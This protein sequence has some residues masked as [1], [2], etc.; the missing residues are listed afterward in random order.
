[1]SAISAWAGTLVIDGY[2]SPNN[3]LA[4]TRLG[5]DGIPVRC[6]GGVG[7][8]GFFAG[9]INATEAKCSPYGVTGKDDTGG[10]L[11][12]NTSSGIPAHARTPNGSMMTGY[13]VN[14]VV[15]MLNVE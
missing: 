5:L 11:T 14:T 1:P 2:L 8:G 10:L 7:G 12:C 13:G 15:A 6:L 4:A 3:A 9:P